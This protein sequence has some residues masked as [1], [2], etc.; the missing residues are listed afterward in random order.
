VSAEEEGESACPEE[1]AA[2]FLDFGF[3]SEDV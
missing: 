3:F 2:D 1:D